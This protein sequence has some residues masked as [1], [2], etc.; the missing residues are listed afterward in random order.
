[1]GGSKEDHQYKGTQVAAG[2][3][4]AKKFAIYEGGGGG[5]QGKGTGE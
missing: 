5:W 3:D 1:V 2:K 4:D